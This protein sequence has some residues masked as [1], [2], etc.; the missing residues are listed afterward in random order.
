MKKKIFLFLSLV[1]AAHAA[2][3]GIWTQWVNP[4]VGTSNQD[5]LLGNTFPGASMPFGMVQLSPD[6]R[7]TPSWESVGYTYRAASNAKGLL[8]MRD[9]NKVTKVIK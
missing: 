9:G 5:G 8:L 3:A 2:V 6:T 1:I 4:F 7:V